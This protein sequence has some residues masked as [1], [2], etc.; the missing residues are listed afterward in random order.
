MCPADILLAL[1][2]AVKFPR[3]AICLS[4]NSMDE[5]AKVQ[6][7]LDFDERPMSFKL[8]ALCEEWDQLTIIREMH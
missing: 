5:M 7:A 2:K 1:A 3:D 4:D 6:L 8:R